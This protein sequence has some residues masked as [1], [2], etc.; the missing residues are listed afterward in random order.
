MMGIRNRE[1][2]ILNRVRLYLRVRTLSY[3]IDLSSTYINKELY[4]K[5]EKM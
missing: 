1:L 2:H 3:K 5:G 4:E